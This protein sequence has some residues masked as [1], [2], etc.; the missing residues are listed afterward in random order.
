[1]IVRILGTKIT[2]AIYGEGKPIICIHGWLENKRVFRCSSYRNFLKGYRV[3]SLDL[4]GFGGSDEVNKADFQKIINLIDGFT[5]ELKLE[6]F[7]I[8]GQC[9]GSA[10]VLDYAIKYQA[11]IE[12]IILV[13]PMLY[14][15]WWFKTLLIPK[16]N[17]VII[18]AFIKYKILS[19]LINR[20]GP[21]RGFKRDIKRMKILKRVNLNAALQYVKLLKEYSGEMHKERIKKITVPVTVINGRKTFRQVKVTVKLLKTL[22]IN[23]KQI[24]EKDK[25]HFIFL[26]YIK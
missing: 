2:Y 6:H 10:F 21:T 23:V 5:Q 13:E 8:L 9:M 1:V 12:K 26:P 4:P 19:G 11:K 25:N 14:L 17:K 20:Y 7:S 24:E 22:I 18:K 3:I 16:V 15:P